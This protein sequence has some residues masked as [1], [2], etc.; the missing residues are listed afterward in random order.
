[1]SRK[2][3]DLLKVF[4]VMVSDICML[5]FRGVN[6]HAISSLRLGPIQGLIC[7]TQQS[8]TRGGMD[9]E[10]SDASRERAFEYLPF[11]FNVQLFE[12]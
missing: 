3:A 12:L 1:M 9:R 7:E 10:G 4:S 2:R 5:T 6:G 11:V 8:F